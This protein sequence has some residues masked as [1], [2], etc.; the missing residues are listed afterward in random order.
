M[1]CETDHQKRH[2]CHLQDDDDDVNW[3]GRNGLYRKDNN[4]SGLDRG[5]RHGCFMRIDEKPYNLRQSKMHQKRMARVRKLER[6]CKLCQRIDHQ[7]DDGDDKAALAELENYNFNFGYAMHYSSEDR[8]D[9]Y[10]G[11]IPDKRIL[12]RRVKCPILCQVALTCCVKLC[13]LGR[14]EPATPVMVR[15]VTALPFPLQKQ[16]ISF[17]AGP[18][19]A[20]SYHRPATTVSRLSSVHGASRRH[21]RNGRDD[22]TIVPGIYVWSR[23]NRCCLQ[24]SVLFLYPGM[25]MAGYDDVD[26]WCDPNVRDLDNEPDHEIFCR[27]PWFSVA[28]PDSARRFIQ[29]AHSVQSRYQDL[30]RSGHLAEAA[31]LKDEWYRPEDL[32][33]YALDRRGYAKFKARLVFV[34]GQTSAVGRPTPRQRRPPRVEISTGYGDTLVFVAATAAARRPPDEYYDSYYGANSLLFR[35]DHSDRIFRLLV[36]F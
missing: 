25:T 29:R 34:N 16:V 35:H 30:A 23:C 10:Y 14:A 36:P 4:K 26:Y 20:S 5:G 32:I 2:C 8:E 9:Y 6:S 17:M 1:T 18:P 22:N 15:L 27:F 33:D 7:G 24:T 13:A 3:V 31:L 11:Q 12:L 28:P 21:C 19:K